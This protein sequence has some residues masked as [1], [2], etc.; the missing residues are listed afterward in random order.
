[1]VTQRPAKPCTPVR[2][3]PA[4]PTLKNQD[5]LL[6][7]RNQRTSN[8][9]R[10]RRT[11]VRSYDKT[12]NP[13]GIIQNPRIGKKPSK[14]PITKQIPTIIRSQRGYFK[15]VRRIKLNNLFF[16]ILKINC[17][18]LTVLTVK[19]SLPLRQHSAEV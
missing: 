2:F 17:F 5:T 4:P 15:T 9:R 8:C 7:Q 3:R 10:Q 1:M 11:N 19:P 6:R 13:K 14:P 16:S 12:I 18:K